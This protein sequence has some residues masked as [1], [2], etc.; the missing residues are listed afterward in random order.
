M[1]RIGTVL[2]DSP[3]AAVLIAEEEQISF[4]SVT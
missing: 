2:Y 4:P 3:G 1:G